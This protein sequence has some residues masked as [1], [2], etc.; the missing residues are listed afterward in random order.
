MLQTKTQPRV[1]SV[2]PIHHQRGVSAASFQPGQGRG[3]GRASLSAHVG[4]SHQQQQPRPYSNSYQRPE[5]RGARPRQQ[6]S[7]PFNPAS[8]RSSSHQS[9]AL[10]CHVAYRNTDRQARARDWNEKVI[11]FGLSG[12]FGCLRRDHRFDWDFKSCKSGCVFCGKDFRHP[13]AHASLD[14]PRMPNTRSGVLD[15]I[16]R[17]KY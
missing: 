11:K 9:A 5:G 7:A 3:R 2:S 17:R 14:C 4:L 8:S 16:H 13:H 1:A 6:P 10:K 12:C 15:A